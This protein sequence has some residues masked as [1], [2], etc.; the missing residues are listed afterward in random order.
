M[1][2]L[3]KI[4]NTNPSLSPQS[5]AVNTDPFTLDP[6]ELWTDVLSRS[7]HISSLLLDERPGFLAQLVES[8][9]PGH[10]PGGQPVMS[11]EV[12]RASEEVKEAAQAK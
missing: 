8:T 3:P 10:N 11:T 2:C 6:K 9:Y 12:I 1:Y 5:Y 7:A 4:T